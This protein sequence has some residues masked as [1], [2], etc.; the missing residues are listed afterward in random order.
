[1]LDDTRAIQRGDL[2]IAP[3]GDEVRTLFEER[4]YLP[5]G[6]PLMKPV[7]AMAGDDVCAHEDDTLTVNGRVLTPFV[8]TT[9]SQGRDIP[10]WYECRTLGTDEVFVLSTYHP[11]S[12]D[13]RYIGPVARHSLRGPVTFLW[14]W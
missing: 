8:A 14:G 6:V 1:M 2:V 11:H 4:G 3:L 12:L 9:D 5:P 10:T 13:S 7:V